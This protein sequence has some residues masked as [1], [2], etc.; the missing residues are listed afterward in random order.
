MT[1]T[2]SIANY[3]NDEEG[4]RTD[5]EKNAPAYRTGKALTMLLSAKSTPPIWSE[6]AAEEEGVHRIYPSQ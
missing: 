3:M 5:A 6:T 4:L 2:Y 1:E